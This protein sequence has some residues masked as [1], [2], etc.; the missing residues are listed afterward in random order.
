MK[1]EKINRSGI[2]L[3][4]RELMKMGAG[5]AIMSLAAGNLG[6]APAQSD[7]AKS[8]VTSGPVA[9]VVE[10]GTGYRN[11][12]NRLDGNGPMDE[13]TRRLVSFA[14]SFDESRLTPSVTD[15]IGKAMVDSMAALI[16]GFEAEP[17]RVA[18]RLAKM[19]HCD[20]KSTVFGYGITST[21]P[22]LAAFANSCA[23]RHT[24]FNDMEPPV[25][26]P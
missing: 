16:S 10:I 9:D 7:S 11:D 17:V 23:I 18:A 4:R 12:A 3:R 14:S 1:D 22:E 24:D 2:G 13:T 5:A 19:N 26:Q 8:P 20:M 25:R 21:S 15:A 6:A